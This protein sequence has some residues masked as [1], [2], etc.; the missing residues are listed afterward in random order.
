M[1]SRLLRRRVDPPSSSLCEPN[2]FP[3]DS[4]PP[5]S[6]NSASKECLENTFSE[7]KKSLFDIDYFPGQARGPKVVEYA[8]SA[9]E[10]FAERKELFYPPGVDNLRASLPEEIE[11]GCGFC[12]YSRVAWTGGLNRVVFWRLG[13]EK[14]ALEVEFG[15]RVDSI[16]TLKIRDSGVV[17]L[18]VLGRKAEAIFLD[19]EKGAT[20]IA[21]TN[22]T[23]DAAETAYSYF[24]NCVFGYGQRG[25][26]FILRL[27]KGKLEWVWEPAKAGNGFRRVM[28]WGI[29]ALTAKRF[30][31]EKL[32]RIFRTMA[33]VVVTR[34]DGNG[35]AAGTKIKIFSIASEGP[36][37]L[38]RV[39][40]ASIAESNARLFDSRDLSGR[41]VD[42]SICGFHGSLRLLFSNRIE[43]KVLLPSL[44]VTKFTKFESR[45]PGLRGGEFRRYTANSCILVESGEGIFLL[46]SKF[47]SKASALTGSLAR[48][49]RLVV[50][51]AAESRLAEFGVF[52]H[53]GLVVLSKFAERENLASILF[54]GVFYSEAVSRPFFEFLA[55]MADRIGSRRLCKVLFELVQAPLDPHAPVRLNSS[56]FTDLETLFNLKGR[57]AALPPGHHFRP[58]ELAEISRFAAVIFYL[59]GQTPTKKP[60]Q[61][62]NTTRSGLADPRIYPTQTSDLRVHSMNPFDSMENSMNAAG[63][64]STSSVV[65][66]V[67]LARKLLP[68]QIGTAPLSLHPG[69]SN[70]IPQLMKR[71]IKVSLPLIELFSGGLTTLERF[72]GSVDFEAEISWFLTRAGEV[73]PFQRAGFFSGQSPLIDQLGV[74]KSFCVRARRAMKFAKQLPT[75]TRRG[76][77]RGGPN[78][79]DSTRGGPDVYLVDLIFSDRFDSLAK[80][81]LFRSR[82]DT[83]VTADL[84]SELLFPDEAEALEALYRVE[85]TRS[86]SPDS[87]RALGGLPLPA[88]EN[89]AEFFWTIRQFPLYIDLLTDRLSGSESREA[90][91]LVFCLLLPLFQRRKIGL[92][93]KLVM[94]IGEAASLLGIIDSQRGQK[95]ERPIQNML[96]SLR[97]E[98]AERLLFD[99]FEKSA[100]KMTSWLRRRLFELALRFGRTDIADK[101][102]RRDM[103]DDFLNAAMDVLTPG[104]QN[105]PQFVEFVMRKLKEEGEF[106]GL[107]KLGYKAVEVGR[108]NTREFLNDPLV[109]GDLY[110]P[111]LAQNGFERLAA[112]KPLG[113]KKME[114][115]AQ[116]ALVGLMATKSTESKSTEIVESIWKG[117]AIGKVESMRSDSARADSA[118]SPA[119]A[120]QEARQLVKILEGARSVSESFGHLRRIL[121]F[122]LLEADLDGPSRTLLSNFA[123]HARIFQ[124]LARRLPAADLSD[125][126]RLPEAL[127]EAQASRPGAPLSALL[128]YKSS[129]SSLSLRRNLCLLLK[130]EESFSE[131]FEFRAAGESANFRRLA[132][133]GI[134]YPF[135]LPRALRNEVLNRYRKEV[136]PA[137]RRRRLQQLISA[138]SDSSIIGHLLANSKQYPSEMASHAYWFLIG[139][140]E[141]ADISQREKLLKDLLSLRSVSFDSVD[142]APQ[143]V[144]HYIDWTLISF[145]NLSISLDEIVRVNFFSNSNEFVH[146]FREAS[147]EIFE[148]LLQVEKWEPPLECSPGDVRYFDLR[149]RTTALLEYFENFAGFAEKLESKEISNA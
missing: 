22:W 91:L 90:A 80:L 73:G 83:D 4:N 98:A 145:E 104:G 27:K 134:V 89:L 126:T 36:G 70:S 58:D 85:S 131:K 51:S 103:L 97:P 59:L 1:E 53:R 74:L 64:W 26:A 63:P 67:G 48:G 149:A 44:L 125:S 32:L 81:A 18:V 115:F 117:R 35:A 144:L 100:K 121:D 92:G 77:S 143:F 82:L 99:L 101:A 62:I 110:G 95:G 69:G 128:R 43:L 42:V 8:L 39:E 2:S 33:V 79:I 14:G 124:K 137:S 119:E 57:K 28:G 72:G 25:R 21:K 7:F 55:S 114:S 12:E 108:E 107:L 37:L 86:V 10:V 132:D 133:S 84:S 47:D 116:A 141:F 34:F 113:F 96:R 105:Q 112:V 50:F 130:I 106:I 45:E 65:A 16:C 13:D 31:K 127:L 102:F 56:L 49:E 148:F 76:A 147:A 87:A 68:S 38:H 20:R 109:V 60:E 122:S 138:N 75:L 120:L 129:F 93:Q 111:Q 123:G 146:L 41:V 71:E 54:L 66:L 136:D 19:W 140:Y 29:K 15:G 88:L 30:H 135:N 6:Q 46:G 23:D 142:L 9:N 17:V 5:L 61:R 11:P 118:K 3:Q 94:L 52:K 24:R 78:S 40:L 139:F